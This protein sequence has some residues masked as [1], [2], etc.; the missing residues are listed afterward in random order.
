MPIKKFSFRSLFLGVLP[1]FMLAHFAH[2]LLSALPTPLLPMIRSDFGLD[3]TQSGI[4]I[5]AF[6]LAY[7]LSQFPAGWLADR[8][9]RRIMITAGILGVG[10]GGLFVGLSQTYIMVIIF[11]VLMGLLGGGYHPSSPPI[12]TASVEPKT[13]GRALG[14]HL[15]GGNAGYF[16]SPLIAAA[17]AVA[18]GWRGPFIVLAAVSI[19][20]GILFY[21]LLG[22]WAGTSKAERKIVSSQDQAPATPGHLSRLVF[23][24]ILVGFTQAIS[25]A[26]GPFVPL[27][28]VDHFGLDE[29]AAAA[30]MGIIY[31]PGLWASPLGG[32]LSDR[33]GRV[34]VVLIAC[35]AVGPLIFLLNVV[36]FVLGIGAILLI[37]GMFVFISMPA[38]EAH[39]VGQTSARNR[40]TVL[41][42]YYL[43]TYGGGGVLTP[44][45]GAIIDHLGF[46]WGFTIAS[47]SLVVVALVCSIWLWG[48]RD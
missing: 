27:Y 41:G 29:A 6:T 15:T 45:M 13:R 12:I 33:L 46:F 30:F 19:V 47:V 44:V 5:S 14:L 31:S 32:Y 39:L 37:R 28:L 7:G 26:I 22:K 24:L 16:L 17:I 43:S 25:M 18:W 11:L 8:I 40:S 10:I 2:H 20:F 48:S 38:A 9:G 23:F 21:I 35:L 34:L 36:P 42:I 1:L 4:V 3:Y